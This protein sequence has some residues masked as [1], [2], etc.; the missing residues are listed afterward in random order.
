MI[1][2]RVPGDAE[3]T[4]QVQFVDNSPASCEYLLLL[5]FSSQYPWLVCL[6]WCGCKECWLVDSG[7]VHVGE[8]KLCGICTD[9]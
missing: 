8:K 9:G 4:L 2:F 3:V 7:Y 5:T 6:P 1:G